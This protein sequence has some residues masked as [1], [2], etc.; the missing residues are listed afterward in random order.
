MKAIWTTAFAAAMQRQ[1]SA[2]PPISS[3]LALLVLLTALT[4]IGYAQT[5]PPEHNL[6]GAWNVTIDFQDP[7]LPTCSAPALNTRDG[8]VVANACAANESPG[9]GQ[10]VRTGNSE[11]ALTFVGLEYAP[12]GTAIGTY[13]VR[14]NV[15]LSHDSQEFNGP[16]RADVL[17]Y[18]GIQFTATG[19]VTAKRIV[20]EPL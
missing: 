3:Y 4:G 7:D 5:G 19:I 2:I 20:V 18:G 10:W 8:G 9:Y 15:K 13:K 14:A 17:L 1:V 6:T 11:F 12:D 16:F